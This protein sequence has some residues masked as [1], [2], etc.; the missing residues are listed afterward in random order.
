MRLLNLTYIFCL[1]VLQLI[2][3]S[4]KEHSE[5]ENVN[6]FTGTIH[7]N[8]S[9][10][11]RK[12]NF[13][14]IYSPSNSNIEE[15]NPVIIFVHGG[16]WSGGDKSHWT[17]RQ[18]EYLASLGF[19]SVSV[20][21]V[22]S[23]DPVNLSDA[24][25]VMHPDHIQ[26]ISLSVRWVFDHIEEY[27]GDPHRIFLIGH[28]AGAH[29]VSLLATNER[30]LKEQNLSFKTIKGVIALDNGPYLTDP[31]SLFLSKKQEVIDMGKR[32]Q[33]AF[34]VT[35]Q[36]YKDATPFSNIK[37]GKHI[38]PFLLIYSDVDY[39]RSP[40]EVF[41]KEL[42][43]NKIEVTSVLLEKWTDHVGV[44]NNLGNPNDPTK[45]SSAVKFFLVHRN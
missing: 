45:V 13:L 17:N 30:F 14:D 8:I 36:K 37:K 23:P 31:L 22:L 16:A 20:N 39:R 41:A 1:L 10:G 42:L 19:I 40:N 15:K 43:K 18:A 4:C 35:S 6:P 33:N 21:Y 26:D 9:Y 32:Y 38:P 44:L 34:G 7:K 28:S 12:S 27:G 11:L 3:C 5:S 29:L 2:C 24:N 25:R